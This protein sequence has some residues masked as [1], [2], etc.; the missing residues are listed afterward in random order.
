[1]GTN[2]NGTAVMLT[3]QEQLQAR[4]A[5][6]RRIEF[7]NAL[8]GKLDV[9]TFTVDALDRFLRRGD[10]VM[11]SGLLNQCLCSHKHWLSRLIWV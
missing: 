8:L 7:L 11:Q 2:G 3:P 9:M 1:M 4:M 10:Q 5:D 6:P